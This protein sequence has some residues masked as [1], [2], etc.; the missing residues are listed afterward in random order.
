MQEKLE[1]LKQDFE[2]KL[3]AVKDLKSL[4]NINN[5]YFSRKAGE[6]TNI[7]KSLKELNGDERK[8]MGALANVVKTEMESLFEIKK[9]ELE[10]NKWASL[11]ENEKIDI[12][13]PKLPHDKKGSLHPVTLVQND[14]EDFFTSMGFMVLDGPELESEFYNFEAV[15]IPDDHPARDMQDTFYI[16]DHA[17]WVM[18]THTSSVQVRAMQKYGAP[19]RMVV[20]GKVFRNE[21]TDP[22]HEHTFHQLEGVVIDKN[23]TFGHMKGVIESMV[24]H[25]Y[26]EDTQ[27]KLRPK[28]YPF[29]E[30]GVNGEVTCF[31]CKGQ[32]CRVCKNTGWLEIFGAGMIHSNVLRAGNIDPDVY[33]GF[34]FGFGL[35]RL[36]MLK[37]D[38]EDI[39]HLQSG[40]FKFL[41]QF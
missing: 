27:V 25:L 40:D 21:S 3:K 17:N 13:Q 23:I 1:K 22:R 32:G 30:P 19:L 20:P 11:L 2:K 35:T 39:R 24:K 14:L 36:V 38:I 4:D 28:F 6:M 5:E 15:N 34:A 8:E 18:R 12:T 7:M 33:Q 29:V 26:G 16:K 41:Q 10:N 37:Y 9:Q 31:L